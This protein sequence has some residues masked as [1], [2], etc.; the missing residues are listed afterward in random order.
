MEKHLNYC[1][2]RTRVRENQTMIFFKD[3]NIGF[4][5]LLSDQSEPGKSGVPLECVVCACFFLVKPDGVSA[6]PVFTRVHHPA[7]MT[8]QWRV[9]AVT[10]FPLPGCLKET[11]HT[12]T[13]PS[14]S[15]NAQPPS[16]PCVCARSHTHNNGV[17]PF[18]EHKTECTPSA[19]QEHSR[20]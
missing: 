1:S 7:Y 3:R 4:S 10:R 14:M 15:K 2:D 19:F 6:W 12:T 13:L 16:C 5:A 18:T 8:F 11:R 20:H 17:V 9:G